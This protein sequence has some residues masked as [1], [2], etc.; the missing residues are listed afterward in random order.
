MTDVQDV[1]NAGLSRG[2]FMRNAAKGSLVLVGSGG[3]LASMNGIAFAKSSGMT[4][5][6]ITVLQTG[7]IAETLAV[8]VYEA[9]VGTYA[10]KFNFPSAFVPYFKAALADE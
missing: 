7:Y 2:Q 8:K 10:K 1:Q 6:D 5:S 4:K 9:I 3:V